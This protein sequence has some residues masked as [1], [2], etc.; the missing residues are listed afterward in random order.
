MSAP[1]LGRHKA[2]YALGDTASN[3]VF[4]FSLLYLLFFYTDVLGLSPAAA[5]LVFVV[6]RVWDAVNNPL[7]GYLVDHTKA[8]SGNTRVYL[9]WVPLPLA[10]ATVLLFFVPPWDEGARFAW[11]LGTYVVWSMLYTMVN[12]PYAAMTAQLTD[13]PRERTA[14]T[15][16]RMLGMLAAVVVVS[17]ATEPLV[18]AFERP[19][20]GWLATAALYGGLAF[21][22]FEACLR[23]TRR[24]PLVPSPPET[25]RLADLGRVLS[26]NRPALVVVATFFFGASAEYIRQSSVVYYVT[27]NMGDPGLVPVFL[28][29]VVLAMVAGNLVIPWLTDRLDKRGTYVLGVTVACA[30]SL[31]FQFL[32]PGQTV[33]VFVVAAIS[34][35]GFS[36]VSTM[37]WAMLPDTVE[38]GQAATGIRGEGLLYS[39]FSFSQKLATAVGGGVVAWALAASGYQAGAAQQSDAALLGIVST[40]GVLPLVFL[41]VSLGV[42]AFYRLDR[43][44]FAE[45]KRRLKA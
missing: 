3:L 31:V 16:A 22:F 13:D 8:R 45:V 43:R 7:M 1:L 23:G 2:A 32:P 40:L 14:V 27:Y 42:V 29:I 44:A 6:A 11:A 39:F 21:V 33:A 35:L 9:R 24:V 26:K 5:G 12:I 28:G 17:V 38:Y 37:G 20:D 34:S 41:V 25:Y 15:S 19:A 10:A 18:S 36:V 30:A 4:Q